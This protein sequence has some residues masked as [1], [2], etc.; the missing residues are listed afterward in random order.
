MGLVIFLVPFE[1][2]RLALLNRSSTR[3]S[4][5]PVIRVAGL[6]TVQG[7]EVLCSVKLLIGVCFALLACR[8]EG[9]G[10]MMD[11]P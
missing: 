2:F 3:P 8:L 5:C 1:Q 10:E 9:A 6:R 11:A 7:L 4:A